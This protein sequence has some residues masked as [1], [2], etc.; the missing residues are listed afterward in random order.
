MTLSQ[1]KQHLNQVPIVQFVQSNGNAVPAH[2]HI[3]EAG[4]STKHF[5]D[6]GGTLRTEKKANL[7]LWTAND[8]EH[9][10]TPEKLNKILD[11]ASPLFGNDDLDLEIEYQ[12][13]SISRFGVDFDGQRF[14]L[15]PQFTNCLASDHCG[16]PPEKRKVNLSDITSQKTACCTPG[17]GCC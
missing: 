15:T 16:I 1:F 9:R 12:T 3:T 2:F 11:I 14:T 5:I 4:L 17:G 6:C 10:L 7:Q 8:L 13:D